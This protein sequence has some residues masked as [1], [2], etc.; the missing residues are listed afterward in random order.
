MA[1]LLFEKCGNA[2]WISHLDLMRLFQRVFKRAGLNL[3]HTQGFSP[4][5]VVSIALPLSVGVESS[6]ELLDFDLEG[7]TLS[8]DVIRD[9]LNDKLVSGV[10]VLSVYDGQKKIK[11][12]AMMSCQVDM[13]YDQGI[14]DGAEA[15][16]ASLFA[17]PSVLVQKRS[18][19]GMTQQDIV[20]LIKKLDVVALDAHT[21]QL[22]AV[23]CCQN[24]SLNP[25][26]LAA[27]VK[28]YLPELDPDFSKSR[29]IEIYDNQGNVFR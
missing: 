1:R 3:K 10:R 18:K 12:L 23:I 20:P 14:P 27:A 19:N 7:N 8:F 5:P 21:I 25:M 26:Q 17:Q 16:I 11:D 13:E 15:Q 2:V 28:L 6:C 29:R 4:R 9:L 24:P 22:Q